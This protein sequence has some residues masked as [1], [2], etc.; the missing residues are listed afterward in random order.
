MTVP[1][2][3]C[4][5]ALST[6]MEWH[7]T[8]KSVL[9]FILRLQGVPDFVARQSEGLQ[10]RRYYLPFC[11]V[12]FFVAL[13]IGLFITQSGP[14]ITPNSIAYIQGGESFYNGQ[15]F[16]S[17]PNIWPPLYGI[18]ISAFMHL[19]LDATQAA[20]VLPVLSFALTSAP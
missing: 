1:Q 17:L 14:G 20:G 13:G 8:G 15:G 18:L 9:N 12:C 3:Q 5:S 4:L 7:L 10:G 16:D 2:L 11:F 19:G 6:Y